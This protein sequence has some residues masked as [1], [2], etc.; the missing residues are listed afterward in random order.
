MQTTK[1]P[2]Q[3][4]TPVHQSIHLKLSNKFANR[5]NQLPD[6]AIEIMNEYFNNHLNNPYPTQSEK[7]N[8]AQLGGIS[9]KQVTAWFSNRRNRS[10]NTKPKRMKRVLEQEIN[11][12][13]DELIGNQVNK[14]AILNKVRST[15]VGQEL[16]LF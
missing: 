3:V 12:I 11:N 15:I 7:E 1:K 4:S 9:V 6:K 13:F 10:Q 8:L 2:N 5:H 16:N 14:E